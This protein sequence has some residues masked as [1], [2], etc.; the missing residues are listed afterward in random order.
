[1]HLKCIS[2]KTRLAQ[3]RCRSE[4]IRDETNINR[5]LTFL[6]FP[7]MLVA[8]RMAQ[9]SRRHERNCKVASRQ[10]RPECTWSTPGVHLKLPPCGLPLNRVRG[11]PHGDRK[12]SEHAW[13]ALGVHPGMQ[14]RHTSFGTTPLSS[15]R[16]SR[17][18][19]HHTK[20]DVLSFSFMLVTCRMIG[21]LRRRERNCKVASQQKRRHGPDCY[22]YKI[23]YNY[24]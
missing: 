12:R 18:D 14:F 10:K 9:V 21:H 17:R 8:C 19:Q 23:R 11:R 13:S 22:G 7:L 3:R 20:A 1:M 5:K 2:G 6:S 4:A 15:G 24:T 16:R